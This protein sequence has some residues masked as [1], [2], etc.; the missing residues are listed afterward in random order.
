M[1]TS[2]PAELS[3]NRFR[4]IPV[5]YGPGVTDEPRVDDI[6]DAVT[7]GSRVLV[8]IAARSL[9]RSR[10]DITLAQCRALVTVAQRG[11]MNLASLAEALDV[12]PSTATRMCDRLVAKGLLERERVEGGVSLTPSREGLRITQAITK[13]RRHELQKIIRKLSGEEQEELL[14]CMEA[15]RLA[16]GEVGEADWAFGWWD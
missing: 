9:D 1:Q 13:A 10:A 15:F 2:Y 11:P 12:N 5:G 4:R 8:G 3:L 14:R 6:L 16:A 7:A